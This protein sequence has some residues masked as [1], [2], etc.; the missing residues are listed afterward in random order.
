MLRSYARQHAALRVGELL[1]AVQDADLQQERPAHE[2]R[3]QRAREPSR[4][5]RRP[6]GGEHIVHDQRARA[7]RQRIAMGLER[8]GPVLQRVR[9]ADAFPGQLAGLPRRYEPRAERG[10]HRPAQDEPAGLD[11][12]HVRDAC[13]GN[14]AA[15]ASTTCRNSGA[16]AQHRGDVLEQD[17]GLGVIRNRTK[18][19]S[20][21]C[22]KRVGHW[23][24]LVSGSRSGTAPARGVVADGHVVHP[25]AGRARAERLGEPGVALGVPARHHF[26]PAVRQVAR[27]AGQPLALRIA[28]HE[29][30]EPHPLHPAGHQVAP[31]T[32]PALRRAF[33]NSTTIGMT[34]SAMIARIT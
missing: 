21:R 10:R 22:G 14:G 8:I 27:V 19:T 2:L 20:H 11:A 12:D 34:D 25:R 6:A 1:P 24:V 4:R 7:R 28:E 33:R 23:D 3:L 31:V 32:P 16:V 9:F 17:P 29:P 5:S 13:S 18:R 26:H 30:A 15:I